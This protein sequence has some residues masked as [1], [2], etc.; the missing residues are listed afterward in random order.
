MSYSDKGWTTHELPIK[1]DN[2]YIDS[3]ESSQ[4][5]V[6]WVTTNFGN[7]FSYDGSTWT[8]YTPDEK[9][10]AYYRI[11][12]VD[13]VYW[14]GDEHGLHRLDLEPSA[15]DTT[16]A[17]PSRIR[18]FQN[19]P[20]PFNPATTISFELPEAGNVSLTIHS[21]T[22]QKV[23]TLESGWMGPGRH[24][25]AWDASGMSSGVYLCRLSFSGRAYT[26]KML[27]LR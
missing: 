23:A 25:V 27:L 16:D 7:A 19:S 24:T 10:S 9:M 18:L 26:R 2:E 3:I 1:T 5:G 14:K 4:T 17:L 8:S 12:A 21:V 6:I 22:G 11:M 15:V 13:G 20:N